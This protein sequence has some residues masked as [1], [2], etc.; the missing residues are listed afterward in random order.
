MRPSDQLAP[1]LRGRRR[2]Y[3]KLVVSTK[4]CLTPSSSAA[5]PSD[6][7]P[8]KPTQCTCSA[9]VTKCLEKMFSTLAC[10]SCALGRA[11]SGPHRHEP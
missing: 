2:Y 8:D 5:L 10:I 7:W 6:C 9:F 3:S 4:T 1:K 11:R